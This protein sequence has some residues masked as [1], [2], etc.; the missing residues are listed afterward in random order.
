MRAKKKKEAACPA[1]LEAGAIIPAPETEPTSSGREIAPLVEKYAS[2]N[3]QIIKLLS[4][5]DF[6][7]PPELRQ[8]CFDLDDALCKQARHLSRSDPAS[9]RRESRRLANEIES[10]VRQW[11]E[12]LPGVDFKTLPPVVADEYFSASK[13]KKDVRQEAKTD[14]D[15]MFIAMRDTGLVISDALRKHAARHPDKTA[16]IIAAS[17]RWPVGISIYPIVDARANKHI[18]NNLGSAIKNKSRGISVFPRV[19][20]VISALIEKHLPDAERFRK[21]GLPWLL[22]FTDAAGKRFELSPGDWKKLQNATPRGKHTPDS[23]QAAA[24]CCAAID[25][26]YRL[27]FAFDSARSVARKDWFD[28]RRAACGKVIS[29]ILQDEHFSRQLTKKLQRLMAYADEPTLD[30]LVKAAREDWCEH[31]FDRC[32]KAISKI[33]EDKQL[34]RK[35]GKM[36]HELVASPIETKSAPEAFDRLQQAIR[37]NPLDAAVQGIRYVNE[38]D[39]ISYIH[40]YFLKGFPLPTPV[41]LIESKHPSVRRVIEKKPASSGPRSFDYRCV[42]QVQN[43]FLRDR[44]IEPKDFR[45]NRTITLPKMRRE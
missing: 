37:L 38:P 24:A 33:L 42:E 2:L 4:G 3:K 19:A 36:L 13:L 34:S 12:L 7:I 15:N 45:A 28:T 35:L 29:D 20:F 16:Q 14:H 10:R 11:V 26:C 5:S 23:L 6:E 40:R 27:V 9:G 21:A 25:Y 22:D 41:P 32:Q 17:T 43:A 18:K 1:G 31:R 39:V 30:P 8:S 44:G